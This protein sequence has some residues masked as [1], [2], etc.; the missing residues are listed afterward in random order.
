MTSQL[1]SV[2]MRKSK[3]LK[4]QAKLLIYVIQLAHIVHYLLSILH[5]SP[6]AKHMHA[7]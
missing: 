2:H 7:P 1:P 5:T 3:L 4:E 6:Q